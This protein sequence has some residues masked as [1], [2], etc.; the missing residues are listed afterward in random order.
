MRPGGGLRWGDR[1]RDRGERRG[2]DLR[3]RRIGCLLAGGGQI[4]RKELRGSRSL[5]RQRRSARRIRSH[6][7]S[8]VKEEPDPDDPNEQQSD[9]DRQREPSTRADPP[10]RVSPGTGRRRFEQ[11]GG[12][13]VVRLRSPRRLG[14]GG[15]SQARLPQRPEHTLDGDA[16]ALRPE[17]LERDGE[18]A[19]VLEAPRAVLL[20]ASVDDGFQRGR[21]TRTDDPEARR[22][23][24]AITITSSVM[25]PA[26][27]AGRP[28]TSS[29]RIVPRAQ[30]SVRRSTPF[31][32]RNCSGDMY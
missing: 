5:A 2:D 12:E 9:A 27:N 21:Q 8:A 31:D 16:P 10:R 32:D 22:G 11:G 25:D 15:I 24:F 28:V 6:P 4:A 26:R 13:G 18:L 1:R 23:S 29:K 19:D 3:A 30:T 20:E 14:G 17:L 7:S